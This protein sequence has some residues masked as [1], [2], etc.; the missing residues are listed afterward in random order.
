LLIAQ[1]YRIFLK[2][3]ISK[4]ILS[5]RMIRVAN[6]PPKPLMIY[7]GNCNFCK[8][9][10][11]RWKKLTGDAVNYLPSQN[12][13]IANR[14]PEVPREQFEKSVQLIETNGEVFCGAEAIF[15]SLAK[16]PK[17]QWPLRCHKRSRVFAR[18]TEAIYRFIA[19]HREFFS[20]LSG[21]HP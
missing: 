6:P 20:W 16:N 11:A 12:P 17:W 9:W 8:Y 7:D 18:L 15:R 4:V 3:E 10:I 19:R 13:E 14:F 1:D 2:K 21:T 5:P